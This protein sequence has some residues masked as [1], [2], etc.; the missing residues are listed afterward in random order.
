MKNTSFKE[1]L[2][3]ELI[4]T[5][6]HK[7]INDAQEVQILFILQ[8]LNHEKAKN[9]GEFISKL[10]HLENI[11]SAIHVLAYKKRMLTEIAKARSDWKE[12]FTQ[13]IFTIDQN[14]LRDFLLNELLAHGGVALV[15]AKIDALLYSPQLAPSTL[16]W[17]FHKILMDKVAIMYGYNDDQ[18]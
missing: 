17:Y 1:S 16:L 9:L 11:V 13:L 18:L 3:Q 10:P 8:D 7:E 14:P 15:E 6:S 4:E 2:K 5:L 12:L